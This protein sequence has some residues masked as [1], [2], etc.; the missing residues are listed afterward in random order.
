MASLACRDSDVMANLAC[1]D[2]DVTSDLTS[3]TV[4]SLTVTVSPVVTVTRLAYTRLV[5]SAGLIVII[6]ATSNRRDGDLTS[7][8]D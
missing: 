4:T 6:V 2:S 3:L 7:L 8:V 5:S 1:R